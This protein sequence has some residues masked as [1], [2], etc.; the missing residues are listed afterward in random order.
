MTDISC[1]SPE[2]PVKRSPKVI[3]QVFIVWA[4]PRHTAAGSGISSSYCRPTFFSSCCIHP[5]EQPASWYSVILIL[6]RF[7]HGL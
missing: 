7:C 6:D 5:L 1:K 2:V 3:C 4:H